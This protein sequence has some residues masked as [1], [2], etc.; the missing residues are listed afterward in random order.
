MSE[1]KIYTEVE[2]VEGCVL[3]KRIYQEAL[4]RRYFDKMMQMCR[5]YTSDMEVA[6]TICNDGFLKVFKK[7]DTFAGKGSLEGWI[8]RIVYHAVSDHFRKDSKYLQFMVFEEFDKASKP[9]VIP[10]LYFDDII[11]LLAK[12]PERSERVFRL[13]AIEGFTHREIGEALDMSENTS[14]W[15][16]SNARKKLQQLLT[17]QSNDY[18]RKGG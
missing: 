14:K 6:M 18:V 13:Y 2:L 12:L 11:K 1:K 8:R 10:G 3:N 9:E 16:M 17:D 7:I 4:Y 15:H 5:R